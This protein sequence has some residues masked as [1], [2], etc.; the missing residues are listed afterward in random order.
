MNYSYSDCN[1]KNSSEKITISFL[2]VNWNGGEVLK[3]CINSILVN[4]GNTNTINYEIIVVDNDSDQFDEYF[5]KSI[6]G[7]RLIKLEKNYGFAYATNISVENSKGDILFIL[8]N[9]VILDK[10]CLSH[11]LNEMAATNYDAFVPQMF[12]PDN[13]P[14]KTIR[15]LPTVLD[16]FYAT[17]GLNFFTEKHDKLFMHHFDYTKKQ[18]VQQPMFSALLIKRKIWDEVGMLDEQFPLL[19]NDV[20]WFFRF[21]KKGKKCLYVPF[22]KAVHIHGMSVN[23]R[24]FK[25]VLISTT[26]MYRYFKKNHKNNIFEKFLL[27]FVCAFSFVTRII[28]EFLMLTYR[29]MIRC[30]R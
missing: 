16:I 6:I 15:G 12:Y 14:Q 27:I 4:L 26:S 10:E 29:H 11:L 30:I 8:N 5:L 13:S 25:K 22:A 1:F 2:I 21:E 28:K 3:T 18:I 9:D 7:I 24:P 17:V 23:K 19:F 20:D